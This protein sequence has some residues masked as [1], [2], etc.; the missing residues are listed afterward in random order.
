MPHKPTFPSGDI[1][2]MHKLAAIMA[3]QAYG[4]TDEGQEAIREAGWSLDRPASNKEASVYAPHPHSASSNPVIVAFRGTVPNSRQDIA[5]D[6]ALAAGQLRQT[7][8]YQRTLKQAKKAVNKYPHRP[9]VFTG[10]SLGGTLALWAGRE[11]RAPVVAFNPG[12]GNALLPRS[13]EKAHVYRTPGD[14]VSFLGRVYSWLPWW[15]TT[16]PDKSALSYFSDKVKGRKHSPKVKTLSDPILNPLKAHGIDRFGGS[17]QT[18]AN[19]LGRPIGDV[20]RRHSV[21]AAQ[22]G[23]GFFTDVSRGI[24]NA[25]TPLAREA[26]STSV[27]KNLPQK[28][29]VNIGKRLAKMPVVKKAKKTDIEAIPRQFAEGISQGLRGGATADESETVREILGPNVYEDTLRA[30]DDKHKI[31]LPYM[32]DELTPQSPTHRFGITLREPMRIA[33]KMGRPIGHLLRRHGITSEKVG[34][35]FFS[36]VTQGVKKALPGLA[37]QAVSAVANQNMPQKLGHDIGKQLAH[38]PILKKAKKSDLE[39]IPRELAEGISDGL[40]GAVTQDDVDEGGE[41]LGG[42]ILSGILSSIGL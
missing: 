7:P 26:V 16:R 10:H 12:V 40:R 1:P 8:R 37:S 15:A 18:L 38:L 5:T 34:G 36:D 22:L 30:V 39:A 3:G 25:L 17:P 9:V 11:Y 20:L 2:E 14:V 19:M 6:V 41:L 35:G 28:L 21:R 23:G 13:S 4:V 24:R 31:D 32:P 42:G 29:G 27:K 33:R